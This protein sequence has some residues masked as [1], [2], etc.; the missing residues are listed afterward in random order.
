ML[1]GGGLL[2]AA[3]GRLLGAIETGLQETAPRPSSGRRHRRPIVGAALLALDELG[4]GGEARS[5]SG[6]SYAARSVEA[7]TL[8][9][10]GGSDG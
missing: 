10:K 7:R 4:A 9:T 1:L 2:Q 5:A 6:V 3:N 8:T